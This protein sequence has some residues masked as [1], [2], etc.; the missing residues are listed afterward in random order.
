MY[1]ALVY[2]STI[3]YSSNV[4]RCRSGVWIPPQRPCPYTEGVIIFAVALTVK[5]FRVTGIMLGYWPPA[6]FE[7]TH[8]V[9]PLSQLTANALGA[10]ARTGE[11]LESRLP[12]E[13]DD[14]V[15]Y[16]NDATTGL[17]D[18]HEYPLSFFQPL[19]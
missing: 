11:S 1:L 3:L 9:V 8:S 18:E 10:L 17:G 4:P 12:R 13:T 16:E 2:N 6:T 14:A 19:D 15:D 7:L 5:A